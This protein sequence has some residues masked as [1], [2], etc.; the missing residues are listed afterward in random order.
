MHVG[1]TPFL[2][3]A[4]YGPLVGLAFSSTR[5]RVPSFEDSITSSA[6]PVG[7]IRYGWVNSIICAQPKGKKKKKKSIVELIVAGPELFGCADW[8]SVERRCSSLV[9]GSNGMW[10]SSRNSIGRQSRRFCTS[11]S[12][13]GCHMVVQPMAATFVVISSDSRIS[14]EFRM[15]FTLWHNA[16][17]CRP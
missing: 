11:I 13:G 2:G 4:H 8:N 7:H 14:V 10:S 12:R 15:I 9:S 17:E 1:P 5:L 16:Y 3:P 6:S